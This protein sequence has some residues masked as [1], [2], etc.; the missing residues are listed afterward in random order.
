MTYLTLAAKFQT[1]SGSI[2]KWRASGSTRP[3]VELNG[4]HLLVKG[5]IIDEI[6]SCS[7]TLEESLNGEMDL[8]TLHP[9]F[10]LGGASLEYWL[11]SATS[12]R[13]FEWRSSKR[14]YRAASAAAGAIVKTLKMGMRLGTTM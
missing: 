4:R 12:P 8:T 7:P 5:C 6:Y 1:T 10:T 9:G 3:F 14:W 2:A 13:M 11:S